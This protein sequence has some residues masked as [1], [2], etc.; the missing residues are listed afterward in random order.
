[1]PRAAQRPPCRPPHP[2]P[3]P[4]R[5]GSRGGAV[6]SSGLFP[7]PQPRS[8]A[9]P[10][11][12]TPPRRAGPTRAPPSRRPPA[13]RR[14]PPPRGRRGPRLAG[15]ERRAAPALARPQAGA[16]AWEPAST[17]GAQERRA[18]GHG[19][20]RARAPGGRL[21]RGKRA[22]PGAGAAREGRRGAGAGASGCGPPPPHPA[23]RRASVGP[24]FK[25][26]PERVAACERARVTSGAAPLGC[27]WSGPTRP[28]GW[29]WRSHLPSGVFENLKSKL[30]FFLP[31]Q[32][33]RL[34]LRPPGCEQIRTR[35]S[36][37]EVHNP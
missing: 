32:L 37:D 35:V 15:A 8:A 21:Q 25:E 31:R 29:P 11:P 36:P 3:G 20:R 6:G 33:P 14:A 12:D 4:G 16:G 27:P 17:P 30:F 10:A 2:L 7:T 19:R 13:P 18:G 28:T 34:L 1:M 9:R 24:G 22:D 23:V 5:R 26:E